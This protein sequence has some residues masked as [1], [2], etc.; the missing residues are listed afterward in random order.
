MDRRF[1]MTAA[2]GSALAATGSLFVPRQPAA[3][4]DRRQPESRFDMVREWEIGP[5]I[6][7]RNYSQGMP[8]HPFA[9]RGGWFF[10]FPG[11]TARDGH[12]HY[13]T[14]SANGLGGARG[15]RMRYRIDAAPGARF[16]PQENPREPATLS[17]YVQRDGDDWSGRGDR[18]A[19]RWYSPDPAMQ[20]LEPGEHEVRVM[21]DEDWK[22]VMGQSSHRASRQ[23]ADT[24]ARAGRMGFTLGSAHGRGHGVFSTAPA[25]ML[26]RDFSVI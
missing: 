26:V 13:L 1:F 24:L 22:G 20:R 8:P 9:V 3:A 19:A 10:E 14:T 12:V 6:R 23:F 17:L 2:T 15:L 25:R 11:P 21:F 5:V 16:I 18:A 7:G 4:Q